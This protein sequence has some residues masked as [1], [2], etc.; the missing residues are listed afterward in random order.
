MDA[1]DATTAIPSPFLRLRGKGTGWGQLKA[2]ATRRGLFCGSSSRS[3]KKHHLVMPQVRCHRKSR[4]DIRL[5]AVASDL[6]GEAIVSSVEERN[7]L[8]LDWLFA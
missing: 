8:F 1:K 5:V 7:S 6:R 3:S 4:P 2:R